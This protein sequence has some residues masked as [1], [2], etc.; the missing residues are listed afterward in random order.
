MEDKGNTRSKAAAAGQDP[1][2]PLSHDKVRVRFVPH[3]SGIEGSDP[4][5]PMAGGMADGAY[6]RFCLP[7]MQATG[8]YANVFS[9]QER[10]WL[11]GALGLDFGALNPNRVEGNFWDTYTVKVGKEG[12]TLDLSDPDQLI[13][14]RV[15]LANGDVVAKSVEELQDRP[16]ASFKFVLVKEADESR[17]ENSKMDATM[18]SYKEFGRIESD[19]DTMRVLVEL[20]D[21]RP[22]AANTKPDFLRSRVNQLIQADAR[23]FLAAAT[24]P[25]LRAKVTLMRGVELGK[26]SRRGDYYYLRSDNTPLCEP[27]QDPTLSAA[28]RWLDM[29]SHQDVRAI[30][31]SEVGKARAQK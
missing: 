9:D 7:V 27:G 6:V 24:D 18:K 20:L 17:L 12:M 13:Q 3:P 26:V 19:Y 25:Q 28:A 11:E 31:E 8:K 22:Y 30:L 23:A 21:G 29:P 14:Y 15:L 4:K 16:R 1:V 5:H 10:E 2:S